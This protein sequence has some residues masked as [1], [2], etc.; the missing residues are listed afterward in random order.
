MSTARSQNLT[1]QP[2]PRGRV[3][4]MATAWMALGAV[5]G[6]G[7]GIDDG[8]GTGV[9][10]FMIAGMIEM[11]ALGAVFGLIGGGPEES[12]VGASW[13]LIVGLAT[14][15]IVGHARIILVADLG[16]IIGAIAGATIRPYF[17]LIALPAL[18]LARVRPARHRRLT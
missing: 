9:I 15:L 18:L 5:M 10:A 1:P 4:R 6:A 7:L 3:R 17:R 2:P 16:L 14:G 12:I 13:G 11:A 8:G